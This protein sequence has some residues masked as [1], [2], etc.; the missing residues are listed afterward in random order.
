MI[1]HKSSRGGDALDRLKVFEGCPPPYDKTKKKVV[2]VAMRVLCL[3]PRRKVRGFC[4][5][6]SFL[7]I[8]KS[9]LSVLRSGP[10]IPRSWVEI[11]RRCEET[12]SEAKGEGGTL[13]QEEDS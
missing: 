2:P 11:P 3:K 4:D 12:G 10:T 5:C 9:L 13:L 1:P 8:H 7:L 6:F